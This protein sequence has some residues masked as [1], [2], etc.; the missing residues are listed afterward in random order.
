VLAVV[1]VSEVLWHFYVFNRVFEIDCDVLLC[2][3]AFNQVVYLFS[4]LL[5]RVALPGDVRF[6]LLLEVALHPRHGSF[7][8]FLLN[9]H[10]P[11]RY[12]FLIHVTKLEDPQL[13]C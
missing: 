5:P 1:E 7:F 13:L 10:H 8:K 11:I 12:R 9:L 2:L 6:P 3:D 4:R